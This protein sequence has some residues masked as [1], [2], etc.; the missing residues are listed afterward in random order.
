MQFTNCKKPMAHLSAYAFCTDQRCASK[1][2]GRFR[3]GCHGN[4]FPCRPKITGF[5]IVPKVDAPC[6]DYLPT[7]TIDLSQMLVKY[8]RN[9]DPLGKIDAQT[10]SLAMDLFK[11]LSCF[12]MQSFDGWMR[13]MRVNL[14]SLGDKSNKKV[15]KQGAV[16]PQQSMY[17]SWIPVFFSPPAWSMHIKSVSVTTIFKG[18]VTYIC[19]NESTICSWGW[20]FTLQNCKFLAKKKALSHLTTWSDQRSW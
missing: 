13:R 10:C 5:G 9:M 15:V 8:T 19:P 6:M 11:S 7:F 14:A 1:K 3:G 16:Y 12:G 20:N 4:R 2:R 18:I 17:N